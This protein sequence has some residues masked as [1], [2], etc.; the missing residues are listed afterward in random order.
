MT[1]ALPLALSLSNSFEKIGAIAALAA[2][3]GIAALSLLMFA[4]ARELKRLREWA[5]RAPERATE[6]EQRVVAEAA[7]RSQHPVPGTASPSGVRQVPRTTPLNVR[8]VATSGQPAVQ[9]G[10]AQPITPSPAQI[11]A[12]A[13]GAT[14]VTGAAVAQPGTNP[15]QPGGA[16]S[17]SAATPQ[18]AP[19][20]TPSAAP[21]SA[22]AAAAQTTAAAAAVSSSPA[23]GPVPTAG[24]SPPAGAPGGIPPPSPAGAPLVVPASS[25]ASTP[26][27]A[28]ATA[29]GT[30]PARG[31]APTPGAPA[32][33]TAAGAAMAIPRAPVPP[34]PS[35]PSATAGG[36]SSS[37]GAPVAGASPAASTPGPAIPAASPKTP[38]V[39][40]ARRPPSPP[41]PVAP[42][43]RAA[44]VA[45]AMTPA[46]SAAV[47]TAAGD[48]SGAGSPAARGLAAKTS[49]KARDADGPEPSSTRTIYTAGPSRRRS[50]A[51]ATAMI[52]GAVI[53]A[54]RRGRAGRQL[55]RELL[56][57]GRRKHLCLHQTGGLAPFA[58]EPLREHAVERILDT[59]GESRGNA[60]LGAQRHERRRARAPVGGEPAAERLLAGDR[61]G[62]HPAGQSSDIGRGVHLRPPRRSHT[63][64]AGARHLAGAADGRVRVPARRQLDRGCDRRSGQGGLHRR[65]L[66]S[67]PPP[68]PP[69][70]ARANPHR[71]VG[72]PKKRV[73]DRRPEKNCFR[74]WPRGDG[75]CVLPRD[76][77]APRPVSVPGAV[78]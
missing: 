77:C 18:G 48:T 40:S 64:R 42:Q 59:R 50:P 30:D 36:G 43:R 76:C 22:G 3:V 35:S 45:A 57:Q 12:A 21:L 5:G 65:I 9:P 51:R 52:V 7:V 10:T 25:A 13:A 75:P 41:A 62:R 71:P 32:P 1:A 29:A 49:S 34:P 19:G 66:A 69:P 28:P 70:L 44:A 47:R 53:L 2:L 72:P 56:R 8:P 78:R 33:A 31:T 6:Q 20:S 24:A 54:S 4:Q 63:G 38:P 74:D 60:G 14:A 61:A 67:P 15:P 26:A 23:A 68:P 16:I 46:A 55:A 27:P 11:A 37:G 17:T 39:P 58:H 73:N